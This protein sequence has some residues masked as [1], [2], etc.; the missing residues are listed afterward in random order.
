MLGVLDNNPS[1]PHSRRLADLVQGIAVNVTVNAP[2]SAVKA[3][4]EDVVDA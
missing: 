1:G 2:D 4:L 3:E